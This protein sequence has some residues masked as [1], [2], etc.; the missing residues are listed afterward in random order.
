MTTQK[1]VEPATVVAVNGLQEVDPLA[2]LIAFQAG[3]FS[4][5]SQAVYR[6]R[7]RHTRWIV[8]RR[9]R[10]ASRSVPVYVLLDSME[11]SIGGAPDVTAERR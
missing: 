2:G 1:S 6:T 7:T 8:V 3:F 9:R 5:T 10:G 11:K 4:R